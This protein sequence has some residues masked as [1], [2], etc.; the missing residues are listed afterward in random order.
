MNRIKIIEAILQTV[1]A[2]HQ[3]LTDADIRNMLKHLPDGN[4]ITFALSLG[5][6]TDAVLTT[7][8]MEVRP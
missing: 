7:P 1:K 3:L 5:I 4:L 6:D 8:K 2:Q